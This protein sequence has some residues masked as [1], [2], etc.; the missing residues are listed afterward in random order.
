MSGSTL[1]WG[2]DPD[3]IGTETDTGGAGGVGAP[4]VGAARWFI[5]GQLVDGAMTAIDGSRL[6]SSGVSV[7]DGIA[8]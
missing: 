5:I 3:H 6:V 7:L 2:G 1:A 4:M 8:P